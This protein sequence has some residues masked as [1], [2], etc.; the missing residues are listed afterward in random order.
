[1]KR[2]KEI[3]II[4]I[5]TK[6]ELGGAQKVCLSLFNELKSQALSTFLISSDSGILTSKVKSNSSV[7]LLNNLKREIS[8]FSIIR[9]LKVFFQLIKLLKKVKK[10]SANVIVH[11][12]STK[13]GLLGRWAALISGIKY[14]IH[15]IHGY[16]FHAHQN[17]FAW[18][19]TY[20]LELIT[21]FITSHYICVSSEDVKT[22]IK[23]FPGFRTK[24]SI[25]RACVESDQF[26]ELQKKLDSY[27]NENLF[28]F[29]T[30]SCF[31]PQKNVIDTLKAFAVVHHK[32]PNTRLEIIGDGIQRPI[33]EQW[34][35]DHDLKESVILHGWQEQVASIMAKWNAFV[36]SSL[37]EGLPCSIVEARL[38]KLPVLS[39]DTGGI[40]DI[41][42]NGQNGFLYSQKDWQALSNGM[43]ELT[44]NKE[45][46]ANLSNHIDNLDSFNNKKMIEQHYNLYY[47]LSH[48]TAAFG[49]ND[50]IL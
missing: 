36:L 11:T 33:I 40:R 27:K 25:I 20:F 24:H 2:T 42:I 30:I 4:Y 21:S 26:I 8:L 37:W 5:I 48:N 38:L 35:R 1:M 17:F 39:Y 16:G 50:P 15:T 3:S 49:K 23:Y 22:G 13:A 6:L 29:G 34:I 14:R 9:E 12:H 45:L 10:D 28:V 32:N 47:T 44:E 18:L 7:Y 41:I 31:K 46:F 43:L 19:F